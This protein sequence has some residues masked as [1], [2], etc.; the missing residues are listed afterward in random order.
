MRPEPSFGKLR[1]AGFPG[2]VNKSPLC[3]TGTTRAPEDFAHFASG[4]HPFL[5]SVAQTSQPRA[6]HPA[7]IM[8]RHVLQIAA[9]DPAARKPQTQQGGDRS[10]APFR[11]VLLAAML[12]APSALLV[13]NSFFDAD[14]LGAI[15]GPVVQQHQQFGVHPLNRPR[16]PLS[17]LLM[18]QFS[19]GIGE[20]TVGENHATDFDGSYRTHCYADA[21]SGS[22]RANHHHH[23][24][25]T[26]S[27]IC[28]G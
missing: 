9:V 10:E 14:P 5:S 2:A 21:R 27:P 7:K 26:Q 20:G 24:K 4:A 18:P 22:G 15:M 25:P 11:L 13:S 23:H 19:G 1:R 28:R 16:R 12:V 6:A 17:G 8:E 3:P